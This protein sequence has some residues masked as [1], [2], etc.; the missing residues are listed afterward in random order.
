MRNNYLWR[1]HRQE[2]GLCLSPATL[3]LAKRVQ[4]SGHK[5]A[6]SLVGEPGCL[7]DVSFGVSNVCTHTCILMH[8]RAPLPLTVA[9]DGLTLTFRSAED[10]PLLFSRSSRG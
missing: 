6:D 1:E 5:G 7:I 4:R 8:T 2:Q 3:E 10:W 9:Q